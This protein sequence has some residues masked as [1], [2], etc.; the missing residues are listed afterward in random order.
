M[1]RNLLI[2]LL[3]IVPCTFLAGQPM[4]D[5]A[6]KITYEQYIA[7]YSP[8]AIKHMKEYGIPAS[9]ILAQGLLESGAGNSALA[10]EA[11]NHFGIKCHNDWKGDTYYQDDD[12]Q[13]ECFRKYKNAEESFRDHALFLT[14]RSRYASLFTLNPTDYK[15]WAHGLKA[16]GYATNPAYAERLINLIEKYNLHQYDTGKKKKKWSLFGKRAAAK[17][18]PSPETT[19]GANSASMAGREIKLLN[20]IK[21]TIAKE[22]DSLATLAIALDVRLWMLRDY[23]DLSKEDEIKPGD[24]VFLQSKKRKGSAPT[25]TLREGE[26]LHAVS[27]QYGIRLKHLQK[28]NKLAEGEI[29]PPGTQLMLR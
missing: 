6:R 19:P 12:A 5:T 14:T 17:P 8:V 16:A 18:D 23:N 13:N 3:V 28:K 1:I 10:R 4:P 7:Q 25:H 9:I 20:G 24:V 2:S 22:G 15:A 21:Y 27:Q 29:P 26:T 11:N